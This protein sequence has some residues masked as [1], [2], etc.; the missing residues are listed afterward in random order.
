MKSSTFATE[1]TSIYR[2]KATL[3]QNAARGGKKVPT[4]RTFSTTFAVNP[5]K[6]GRCITRGSRILETSDPL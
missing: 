5:I 4:R 3:L 6:K 2:M 1:A